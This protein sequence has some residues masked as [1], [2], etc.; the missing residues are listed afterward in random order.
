MGLGERG[1]VGAWSG[2]QFLRQATRTISST[3]HHNMGHM[4]ISCT[5]V[6]MY[7]TVLYYYETD[8]ELKVEEERRRAEG[9]TRV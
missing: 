3:L 5:S 6:S 9:L 4:C 8:S 1:G 2:V 7:H